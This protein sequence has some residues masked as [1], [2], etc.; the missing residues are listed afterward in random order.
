MKNRIPNLRDFMLGV[1]ACL[2]VVLLIG[3]S[4][5][6]PVSGG[7]SPEPQMTQRAPQ[8]G[9]GANDLSV[10]MTKLN[11]IEARLNMMDQKLDGIPREFEQ[12][13]INI[14]KMFKGVPG[15]K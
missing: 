5:S 9:M 12:N 10:I 2:V 3:S 15:Y 7:G 6:Q 8:P 11:A 4:G 1:L 13:R 14:W